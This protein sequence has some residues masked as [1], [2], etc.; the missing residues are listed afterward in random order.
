MQFNI[1]K[2]FQVYLEKDYIFIVS[3]LINL[4]EMFFFSFLNSIVNSE[5]VVPDFLSF[6]EYIYLSYC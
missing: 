4:H 5:F 6:S 1:G 2:A 3:K